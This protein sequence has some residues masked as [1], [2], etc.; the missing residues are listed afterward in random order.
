MLRRKLLIA[1]G[2]LA[3]TVP[4][5]AYADT[6]VDRFDDT[7]AKGKIDSKF[8]PGYADKDSKVTVMVELTG[9]PVAVVEAQQLLTGADLL[10]LVGAKAGHAPGDQ[11]GE[12]GPRRRT[13]AA[14]G[15]DGLRE[16]AELGGHDGD[17]GPGQPGPRQRAGAGEH[18]RPEQDPDQE[19]AALLGGAHEWGAAG[20]RRMCR[21]A[22][23]FGVAGGEGAEPVMRE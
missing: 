8:V 15:D 19:P 18:E 3:L 9:D 20:D 5:I 21:L 14:R 4:S 12:G 6:G 17:A 11:G 7:P 1:T 10:A 13:H 22:G 23:G 16:G 2:A